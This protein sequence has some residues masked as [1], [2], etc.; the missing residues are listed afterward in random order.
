MIS[1]VVRKLGIKNL[2][3]TCFM[4]ATLQCLAHTKQLTD[5]F[6]GERKWSGKI[7]EAFAKFLQELQFNSTPIRPDYLKVAYV[8][9]NKQRACIWV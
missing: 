6:K 4:S 7:V 2:G 9:C 5:Y 8:T 1:I 3:N